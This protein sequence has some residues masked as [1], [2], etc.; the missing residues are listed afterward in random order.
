VRDIVNETQTYK[1]EA[2]KALREFKALKTWKPEVTADERQAGLQAL[3]EKLAEVYALPYPV[4]IC[5]DLQEAFA[6]EG[7]G[8]FAILAEANLS[9]ITVLHNFAGARHALTGI[10]TGRTYNSRQRWAVNL[11]KKV[12]PKQ[13]EKLA[14]DVDTGAFYRVPAP[15]EQVAAVA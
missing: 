4:K 11:F 1:P 14:Q 6:Y 12:Y 2:I 3:V 13:F 7:A 15:V 5:T 9:I 8:G 10:A